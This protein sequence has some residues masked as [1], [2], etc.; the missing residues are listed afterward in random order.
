MP[1]TCRE[2]TPGSGR[3][4]PAPF[5]SVAADN[6]TVMD[7]Q[8]DW[9]TE[10]VDQLDW[11]WRNQARPRLDGLG[12]DE[13][14]WEPVL[15]SWNVRPRGTG[16]YVEVGVG[17][18]IID[19]AFPEPSPP[20]FTTIAWRLSHVIVGVF[21]DR[22]A[23]YFGGPPISYPDYDYPGTADAALA[24]LDAGYAIWIEGVR[25]LGADGLAQRCRE[26]GHEE[27]PMAALVLHINREAIHHLAEVALLRDLWAHRTV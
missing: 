26:L 14:R 10:L 5:L 8:L 18:Y 27:E 2:R 22:N 3:S 17:D 24:A 20:P 6:V 19:Y 23:R 21:G 13:Y 12:D 9:T 1:Q 4:G 7:G 25:G 11:H 15:D 16:R